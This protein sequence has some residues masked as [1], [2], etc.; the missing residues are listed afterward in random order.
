M[1]ILLIQNGRVID[2]S[3]GIDR[4]ADVLVR[5]GRIAAIGDHLPADGAERFDAAGCVVAPGFIDLHCHLR[6]PGKE[7]AETIE[8]G[9]KAAAAGG[10]TSVLAMPNTHPVNDNAAVTHFIIETARQQSPVNVFPVGAI[11][12]G[13]R[14]ER[15]APIAEMREAGIVA[16]SD[17]GMPVMNSN[18]MR[19]AMSYAAGLGLTV[20]DHCEDLNLSAGGQMHEGFTAVRYGLAGI[21]AASEDVMVARDILLAERTGARFHVAH[22]STAGAL[23]MVRDAKRRGLPVSCEVTPHH[24]TLIDEDLREYDTNFKMKPP[25]RGAADREALLRGLADGS[26]DAIATDHAPHA[27]SEKMQEFDLAPFGVI[28]LETALGLALDRLYHTGCITLPRL[29]ELLATNPA[30]IVGLERGTLKVGAVADIT[31]FDPERRWTYDVNQSF[32]RSRNSPFHGRT[33]RGG[34]VATIVGGRIVWRSDGT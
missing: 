2:P 22:L 15:M 32:S 30:R 12:E 26:V 5:D 21:S 16:V 25:L 7:H 3:Q 17:D 18:L 19:Q 14:G 20:V 23:G 34:P 1:S 33:F 27:G 29:V 9:G 4:A 10:F 11:S 8:S 13:S 31:L 6:E 28:G 24:F